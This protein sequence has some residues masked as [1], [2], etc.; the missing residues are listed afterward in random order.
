MVGGMLCSLSGGINVAAKDAESSSSSSS[1]KRD[2]KEME[3]RSA[4]YVR[5]RTI[6]IF[7][8][9]VW[10]ISRS[11]QDET[12]VYSALPWQRTSAPNDARPV[13]FHAFIFV[14]RSL[15]CPART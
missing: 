10:Q 9:T 7:T 6:S 11:G 4:N 15:H 3:R 8:D 14:L 13:T 12:R 5:E 1:M 2:R